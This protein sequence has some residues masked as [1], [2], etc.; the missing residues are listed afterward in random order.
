MN[1]LVVGVLLSMSVAAMAAEP[2]EPDEGG[3]GGT[4]NAVYSV[5]PP[6]GVER[7]RLRRTRAPA[8]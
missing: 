2:R 6:A 5:N 3:M 1:K 8:A 4:G 7:A